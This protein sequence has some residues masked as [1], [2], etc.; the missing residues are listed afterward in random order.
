MAKAAEA[1]TAEAAES[2]KTCFVVGPIGEKGSDIRKLADWLLKGI[3]KPVLESDRFNYQV[4]RADEIAEPGLIT[5]QVIVA[6]LDSDLVVADLTG[7]NP[8]AFYELAIRHMQ[9][10][11]IIHIIYEGEALPFDIKDYRTVQYSMESFDAYEQ[12]KKDLATQ[13][14]AIE[15][16]G[17]TVSN[18]ITK[19][20]GHQMLTSSADP[21][22]QILADLVRQVADLSGKVNKLQ[23]AHDTEKFV[24]D[25][26]STKSPPFQKT[27]QFGGLSE[28]LAG[29]SSPPQGFSDL[30]DELAREQRE[31]FVKVRS[32]SKKEPDR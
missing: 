24:Q 2:V 27:S 12:A 16:E 21:Q 5:N 15:A 13:V 11:P 3:I 23:V 1:G 14:T 22:A 19:A 6:A 9:E 30:V 20:R 7:L 18:P 26:I 4:Q 10:K 25:L 31:K 29:Y 32:K 28:L 17:Y 8:N